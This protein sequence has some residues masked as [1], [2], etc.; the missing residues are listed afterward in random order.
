MGVQHIPDPLFNHPKYQTVTVVGKGT[1]GMVLLA[2]NLLNPGEQVAIKLLPLNETFRLPLVEKEVYNHRL[3]RHVH[4]VEF[5]ELI[6]TPQH[7]GIVM[8]WCSGGTLRELLTSRG[9]LHEVE[10]RWFFQQLIW[11]MDYCHRTVGVVNRDIKL[12]N[13]LIKELAEWPILKM[14]DFGYSKHLHVNSAPISRVGTSAYVAPEVLSC[15]EKHI[16]YDG[17]KTDIWSAGVVLYLM[18][19]GSFPFTRGNNELLCLQAI[20]NLTQ[21]GVDG[22]LS[23]LRGHFSDG[24]VSLLGRLLRTNP[25]ERITLPE[26]LMDPWF[27]ELLPSLSQSSRPP[28]THTLQ[29]CAD[30]M[31]QAALQ[32][33]CNVEAIRLARLHED[34][35][36]I[37]ESYSD[38]EK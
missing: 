2:Q 1:F 7:L 19:V 15:S 23:R 9:R 38:D 18:L 31:H 14:C 17:G 20:A 36:E 30:V 8:E 16:P 5:R 29:Q 32:A 11:A 33:Q 21:A 13:L 26:I 28:P 37:L 35:Q 25:V 22:I 6:C 34:N 4:V 10:A 27:Q 12:E 3:L 24:C